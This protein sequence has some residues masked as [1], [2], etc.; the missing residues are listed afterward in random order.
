MKHFLFLIIA[1]IISN[2][3]FAQG[4]KIGGKLKYGETQYPESTDPATSNNLASFRLSNLI[5][6]SLFTTDQYRNIIPLLVE[7]WKIISNTEIKYIL[8]NNVKWHDGSKFSAQDVLFTVNA[9]KNLDSQINEDYRSIANYI[10]EVRV[11]NDYEINIKLNTTM[12]DINKFFVNL[13]IY[14]KHKFENNRI[15][16]SQELIDNPIGTG[17]YMF[18]RRIRD[19]ELRLKANNNYH[20][21]VNIQE[22]EISIERDQGISVEKLKLDAIDMKTN[23]PNKDVGD[24]Q[25]T[26]KFEI[27]GYES[28]RFDCMSL[29]FNNELLRL[30]EIRQAMVYGFDRSKVLNQ[31]YQGFGHLI[32]GPFAPGSWGNNPNVLPFNYDVQ[33]AKDLL[34]QIGCTDLD[35]DG[36][37]EYKNKPLNFK[38]VVPIKSESAAEIQ[39]TTAFQDYM[40]QIGIRITYERMEWKSFLKKVYNERDF[41]IAYVA[42]VFDE[43]SNITPLFHSQNTGKNQNNII[44]YKNELVDAE[45]NKFTTSSDPEQQRTI[46]YKLHSL[47]ADDCPYIFLW[48]LNNN[49]AFHYKVRSVLIDPFKF[50]LLTNKWYIDAEWR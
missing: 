12:S 16:K 42:W 50:F 40:K 11:L 19:R 48:T 17:P 27:R 34:R 46:Y 43:S 32:S 10:R 28:L 18:D 37:L 1:I 6:E 36:Y 22:V 35:N 20:Q 49:A 25:A 41:D 39:V 21:N 9:F 24:L 38:L 14:P 31:I 7:E 13:P 5:Y 26:G 23:V 15:I 45:L 47:L 8:K 3:T 33:K 2:I 44:S 29:N 30:K 4:N